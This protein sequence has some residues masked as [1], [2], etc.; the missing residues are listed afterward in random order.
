MQ[1]ME[2]DGGTHNHI[3]KTKA[4]DHLTHTSRIQPGKALLPDIISPQRLLQL[5]PN[6][7][8][9]DLVEGV[10]TDTL[11]SGVFCQPLQA[12]LSCT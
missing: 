7:T 10:Q 11:F 1:V 6:L 3:V 5:L 8:T 9:L 2:K 12:S 4:A